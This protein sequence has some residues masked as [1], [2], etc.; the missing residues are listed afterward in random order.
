M[1]KNKIDTMKELKT[2][3]DLCDML[4]E[5]KQCTDAQIAK[6]PNGNHLYTCITSC[7]KLDKF[8]DIYW[9]GNKDEDT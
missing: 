7:K 6:C 8:M 2:I 5:T 1:I 3:K 9:R 4:V